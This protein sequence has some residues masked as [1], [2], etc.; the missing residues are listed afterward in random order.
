MKKEEGNTSAFEY[1]AEYWKDAEA[2]IYKE[3]KRRRA[4]FWFR[5]SGLGA[6][7]LLLAGSAIY[8]TS[9]TKNENTNAVAQS[10]NT[11]EIANKVEVSQN[12]EIEK[13]SE[14]EIKSEHKKQ[15]NFASEKS[16][17]KSS[18][19]RFDAESKE[20]KSVFGFEKSD[21]KYFFQEENSETNLNK[22][23]FESGILL[24]GKS[25]LNESDFV[26]ENIFAGENLRF[27]NALPN[28]EVYASAMVHPNYGYGDADRV[29]LLSGNAGF[30]V[31]RKIAPRISIA[32]G[33]QY[34]YYRG[35]YDQGQH[36]DYTTNNADTVV[37]YYNTVKNQ[38][39]VSAGFVNGNLTY[40]SDSSSLYTDT[41]SFGAPSAKNTVTGRHTR[42]E[43]NVLSGSVLIPVELR[44]QCKRIQWI[45][46]MSMEYLLYNQVEVY[47]STNV[48]G[49]I[50]DEKNT[51][52]KNDFNGLNRFWFNAIVGVDY[53]ISSSFSL[54]ARAVVGLNDITKNAYF[55]NS[56]NDKNLNFSLSLRYHLNSLLF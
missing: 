42:T 44:F 33:A 1:K 18:L 48:S 11:V 17:K 8:F 19:L 53:R 54:G 5:T 25:I 49:W 55:M 3:E 24:V 28:V 47:E 14:V 51:V 9:E 38:N 52:Q 31:S 30:S 45:A 2:L 39:L 37:Q 6:I 46:G 26:A 13:K 21:E 15:T 40:V 43:K 27:K 12:I 35:L 32:I 56:A 34:N 23:K 50:S 41:L 10:K 4:V 16:L 29:W 22:I 7:L 20:N 36:Q